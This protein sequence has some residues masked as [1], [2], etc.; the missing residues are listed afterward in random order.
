MSTYYVGNLP[1]S[2]SLYHH[3]IKGM[4]WGVRRYQNPDGT[5]TPAGIARYR[6]E[7]GSEY[8]KYSSLKKQKGIGSYEKR[9]NKKIAKSLK[10]EGKQLEKAE[11]NEGLARQK[12]LDKAQLQRDRV[13]L[14]E[15]LKENY[16]SMSTAGKQKAD[17][18]VKASAG[19]K[20]AAFLV[21]GVPAI[22]VIAGA[23]ALSGTKGMG[24]DAI[25]F[26][27]GRNSDWKD[28]DNADYSTRLDE[29]RRRSKVSTFYL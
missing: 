5:L 13:R 10:R 4:K 17:T 8:D 16:N 19:L 2:D 9:L 7:V 14:G 12:A 25:D 22:P 23:Y 1:A 21:G 6:T 28:Y 24:A 29:S 3:G 15:A 18:I 26:S 20:V 11:K 27:Y